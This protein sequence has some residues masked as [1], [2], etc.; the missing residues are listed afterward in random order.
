MKTRWILQAVVWMATSTAVLG[1]SSSQVFADYPERPITVLVGYAAGGSL[2]LSA[3]A[4]AKSA[5]KI[6]GKP[7][8]VENKPGGTGIVSL[9]ALLSQKP[10]G[11]TLCAVSSSTLLR[12]SQLHQVP[13]KAFTS[14]KPIIGY[15]E[16]LLAVVVKSDAPWKTLA[17]LVKDARQNPNKIRY[18]SPGTGSTQHTTVME[19]IL[20]NDLKVIHV[21]YKGS[22]EASTAILGGHVDFAAL[23]SEFVPQVRSGQARLLAAAH[24]ERL[25][26][27]PGV[28]TLLELGY[29]YSNDAVFG[30]VGS[31]NLDPAVAGKLEEAFATAAKEKDYLEALN[32]ISMRPVYYDSKA[33]DL[34][35]RKHWK[36]I[37]RQLKAVNLISEAATLPE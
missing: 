20:R 8:I 30:I 26:M 10:D 27:F 28:P 17:D 14:F 23:T 37:N 29:D 3:R 21:P 32:R 13:F 24:E 5:E 9:A 2:D 15:S 22:I 31:A 34:F 18:A 33:F 7:V 35:L 25:P 11:Y 36:K 1:V 12:A 6:L 16:P 4:L 19:I